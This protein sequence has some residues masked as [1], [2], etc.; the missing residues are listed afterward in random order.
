MPGREPSRHCT[1]RAAFRP[2]A[3]TSSFTGRGLS[4]YFATGGRP[5]PECGSATG[6]ASAGWADSVVEIPTT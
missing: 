5:D 6:T 2:A 3:M 1:G 4:G